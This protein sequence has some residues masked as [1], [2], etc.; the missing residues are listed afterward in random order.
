MGR[1]VIRAIA[2]LL[3]VAPGAA[4]AQ[5]TGDDAE[6]VQVRPGP[7]RHFN[8]D[9]DDGPGKVR[10]AYVVA[11]DRLVAGA[12]RGKY[13]L[14]TFIAA[15]RSRPTTGWIEIA[16]LAKV[17]MPAP[18][19]D[20]W[21]GNWSGWHADIE[22][23]RGGTRD[24]LKASGEATY[25]MDDKDRVARGAINFGDFDGQARPTGDRLTIGADESCTVRL[26]LLGPY[27]LAVDNNNC[28]GLNVSFTGVYRR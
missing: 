22:I 12:I 16:A 27:L 3:A 28:G 6:L 2:M 14:V 5:V 13:R 19:L 25:G 11:G 9:Q 17:A 8:G 7:K 10:A 18:R 20:A 26:R 21:L 24:M 4:T 15:G 1:R 23:A